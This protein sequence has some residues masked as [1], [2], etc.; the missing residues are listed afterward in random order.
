MNSFNLKKGHNLKISGTPKSILYDVNDP[1]LIS[2]HPSRKKSFKTKLL[3]KKNDQVK[4]GTPIYFDKNN[5]EVLYVSSVSGIVEDISFGERRSVDSIIIKN[6]KKYSSEIINFK[7]SKDLLLK[8]GLWSLIRQKPF[9]KVPNSNSKPKSFFISSMPTGPF[10]IDNEFLFKNIDNC[11]QEG[12][13]FLKST[14]DCEVNF[15]V[16]D[17]TSFAKLK[18]VNFYNFNRLHPSGNVGVQ[19]HHIDPIKNADDTRWYLSLQDLNRVGFYLKNNKHFIYKYISVGGNGV[20]NPGFYKTIIGSP[21]VSFVNSQSKDVRYISG[22]VLSG[23]EINNDYSLD[24]YDDVLSVI[25]VQKERD[26]IGW[27]LPGFSKYSLTNTFMSKLFSN[28]NSRLDTNLNGSVRTIIPMG[29]WESVLPMDIYPEFLVKSIL[30]KDIDMMEKLGIYE[31]SPEDYSLCAFSCQSKVEVSKII[32]EGLDL[33]E[34]E[35]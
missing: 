24:F 12:I 18:N 19:I 33:I 8:S 30:A 2:F 3:V 4:V 6:D 11:L 32:K 27:L 35:L 31:S 25:N 16:S 13:D 29:N 1:S 34:S 10:A 15:S 17:S 14:F 21:I 5:K 7:N 22:D 20:A 9:S 26:F 23:C 28:K